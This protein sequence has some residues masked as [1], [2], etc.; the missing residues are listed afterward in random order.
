VQ[1][2]QP[3]SSLLQEVKQPN[4]AIPPPL[5]KSLKANSLT[6]TE[7]RFYYM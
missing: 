1:G 5:M 6:K 7:M 2:I 4:E 3:K